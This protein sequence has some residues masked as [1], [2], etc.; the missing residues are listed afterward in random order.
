ME[1]EYTGQLAYVE[2]LKDDITSKLSELDIS[3]VKNRLKQYSE[4]LNDL[5]DAKNKYAEKCLK[6]DLDRNSTLEWV[7]KQNPQIKSLNELKSTLENTLA[8]LEKQHI[9]P[10]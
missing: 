8:G 10:N 7:E 6:S 2:Y 4:A 5:E 3:Q 1:K 9:K